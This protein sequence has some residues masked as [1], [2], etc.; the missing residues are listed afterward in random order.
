MCKR[1]LTKIKRDGRIPKVSRI[2]GRGWKTERCQ[3][4]KVRASQGRD[5][6]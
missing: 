5:A 6:G 1:A 3:T 4:R 2:N